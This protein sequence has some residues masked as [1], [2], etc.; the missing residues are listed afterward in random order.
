[1]AVEGEISQNGGKSWRQEV[2]ADAHDSRSWFDLRV[3]LFS[4][5]QYMLDSP[6]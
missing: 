6:P 1:M 4:L 5:S 3:G 2:S